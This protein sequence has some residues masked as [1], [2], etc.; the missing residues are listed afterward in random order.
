MSLVGSLLANAEKI[1]ETAEFSGGGPLT[2]LLRGGRPVEITTANDWS[3]D[4]LLMERQVD[5]VYRVDRRA[6]KLRV[7]ARSR[8]RACVLTER[9]PATA[10]ALLP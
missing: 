5:E 10:L 4:A 7:E 1:L 2:I 8:Y 6:G 3:L 9:S